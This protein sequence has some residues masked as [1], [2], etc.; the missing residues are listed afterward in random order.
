MNKPNCFYCGSDGP[1]NKE[2]VFPYSLGGGGDDWTLINC[3]CAQCNNI[4]SSIERAFARH[5]L[6][7]L[8]RTAYGPAGRKRKGNSSRA[9]PL[10]SDG[11]FLL[12]TDRDLAYEAGL[13]LG[14]K[15]YLRAQ[16]IEDNYP[17]YIITGSDRDELESLFAAISKFDENKYL[18]L[19]VPTKKDQLF[20]VAQ[21]FMDENNGLKIEKVFDS[22]RP[23][24]AWYEEFF[25]MNERRLTPRIFLDD[26]KRLVLRA[27]SPEYGV[28]FIGHILKVLPNKMS[29]MVDG[30]RTSEMEVHDGSSEGN[31]LVIRTKILPVLSAR[32]VA[33]IGM[34]FLAKV[35]GV[36]ITNDSAFD[37]I[38]SFIKGE[39]HDSLEEMSFHV[40]LISDKDPF[41]FVKVN[42]EKHWAALLNINGVLLFALKLY[43]VGGYM[44]K[45][46]HISLPEMNTLPN[47]D[48]FSI[49]YSCRT[50]K[51][52]KPMDIV[53]EFN[54]KYSIDNKSL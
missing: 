45:L 37:E 48:I 23:M 53:A 49:D 10:Y 24:G 5:S 44:A 27:E 12:A 13:E 39:I 19:E 35:H 54:A 52:L 15:P 3:V 42:P 7:A 50:I 6:E 16:I 1:F 20:K 46:G 25:E 9:V 18:T 8:S 51:M 28:K 21:L 26:E 31:R 29:E 11:A 32:A 30:V 40:N 22:P 43:G 47:A 2:H 33:K 34:N 14:L 41:E 38:K 36:G 4:F 17:E